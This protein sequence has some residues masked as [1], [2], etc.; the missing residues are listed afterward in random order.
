MLS[1]RSTRVRPTAVAGTFYPDE[2][3]ALASTVRRLLAD[4]TGSAERPKA[5][6]APHAGYIYS[7]PIAASA[8]AQLAPLAEQIRR[9]VLLG[10]AHR[11]ALRGIALPGVAAFETPLGE[12]EID[13]A[14]AASLRDLPQV[15]ISPA[16]HAL[17][18]SLEVQLPFLQ[19]V[20]REFRLVPLAVGDA[21]TDE[22]AEVIER[23]WGGNETLIVISSDLSHYLPYAD[24]RRTDRAT[25]DTVLALEP[26]LDHAQACGA[27][28]INGLLRAARKHGLAPRLND[29]RN[30]GDTAGDRGRVVGYASI[31]F[32]KPQ[33]ALQPPREE[34][35]QVLLAHARRAIE[36]A[37]GVETAIAPPEA[38]FLDRAGATFVTLRRNGSLRGCIGTLDAERSLREDVAHNARRAAFLDPRFEPL[39]P[40]ELDELVVEV[41]LLSPPEPIDCASEDDLIERLDPACDGIVLEYRGRRATFLPQVWDQLPDPRDF[42]RQLKLKA[43]LPAEFWSEELRIARYAVDKWSESE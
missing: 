4:A 41:S 31:S 19:T 7:G 10:P 35:G 37:L 24:A 42:L 40:D 3:D 15:V 11:V 6:I 18:H 5:L 8:Y 25:V 27:T 38:G 14:A 28:P 29:L 2:P 12:I 13:E 16:A 26:M 1:S 21:S 33:D 32:V 36:S 9:V 20:L 17:E 43:G 30:S 34:H 39:R 23:L 22:V